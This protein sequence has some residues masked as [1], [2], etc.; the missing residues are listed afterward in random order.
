MVS[1]KWGHR[2]GVLTCGV[3]L[4]AVAGERGSDGGGGGGGARK[5]ELW[6]IQ[7]NE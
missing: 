5:E 1:G 2:V 7:S 3:Q 6:F 4:V